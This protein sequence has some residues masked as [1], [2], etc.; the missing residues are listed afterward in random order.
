L[1]TN[2]YLWACGTGAGS[3]TSIAGL[4][5]A[6]HFND[7]LTTEV[8]AN[9]VKA[10]FTLL[11]GSWLGD[12]DS[13]DNMMRSILA[14]PSYGLTCAWSGRPH[15]F[16]HHMALGE[17]IGFGARLTQNNHSG[18][19]YQ[20]Q[21][22][23]CAGQTHIALMGD[24]TLRM[25]VV[26][27]PRNLTARTNGAELRLS[28]SPSS[29][30]VIGY[31]VY[32]SSNPEGPFARLTASLL[33]ANN[34]TENS[35]AKLS[36]YMVRA[37]K[38]ETSASGTY[39]NQSQGVFLTPGAVAATTIAALSATNTSVISATNRSS[40]VVVTNNAASLHVTLPEVV[41]GTTS[42]PTK[43]TPLTPTGASVGN[44]LAPS[45]P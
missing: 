40:A 16:L 37:V 32:G 10:V 33:S 38:L 1:S 6:N 9:D 21:V 11:F 2:A 15:W 5:N 36:T 34:Y 27:P 43:N 18:G 39:Y 35:S 31:Y 28:W 8:M 45:T 24:P 41:T 23:S 7:G 42:D 3:Y 19:L 44:L 14:L 25:H 17:T 20:N 4:G 22:N 29:D 13:E 12:W 26:S 30:S